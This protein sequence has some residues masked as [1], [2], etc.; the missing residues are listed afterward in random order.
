MVLRDIDAALFTEKR[1]ATAA[2]RIAFVLLRSGVQAV[3]IFR[4]AAWLARQPV[5]S[6]LGQVVSLLGV[7]LTGAELAPT[8]RIGP[9]FAIVHSPGV[10]IAGDVVAG[11]NL[12][13]HTGVVMGHQVGSEK[14]GAPV[15]GDGIIVGTGAKLLGPI[16]VGSGARIGAGAVVI[17]DVPADHAAVGVPARTFPAQSPPAGIGSAP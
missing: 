16:E 10:V 15:L 17:A 5:I 4:L 13:I 9:G 2:N 1:P 11:E 12:W 7:I 6:P 3:L 14:W 8:A